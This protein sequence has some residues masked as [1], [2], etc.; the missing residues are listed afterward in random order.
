[1]TIEK[2]IRDYEG[3]YTLGE[4]DGELWANRAHHNEIQA[5]SLLNPE[6]VGHR[7]MFGSHHGHVMIDQAEDYIAR[8]QRFVQGAYYEGFLHA[9][10]RA[11]SRYAFAMAKKR[12]P[13]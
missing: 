10:R 5:L 11:R 13:W 7:D 6:E 1:M 3:S 4:A 2:A 9:V 8:D 12:N